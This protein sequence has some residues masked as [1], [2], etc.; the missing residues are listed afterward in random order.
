MPPAR[1]N[2]PRMR[3]EDRRT[4]TA[5][6]R[7]ALV[8][9][10]LGAIASSV[11]FVTRLPS[12]TISSVQVEHAVAH[13]EEAIRL[14]A[15]HVLSGSYAFVIPKRF[16]YLVSEGSLRAAILD[17]VPALQDITVEQR[18]TMLRIEVE[19][20]TP[21][22]LWCAEECY[23]ID[24][25]GYAFRAG[26][27]TSL[28][29]YRGGNPRIGETVHPAFQDLTRLVDAVASA[30]GTPV[31]VVRIADSDVVATLASG[32]EVR[33]VDTGDART[34]EAQVRAVLTSRA[35]AG[36]QIEYI[37][38]RFAGKVLAKFAR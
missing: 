12:V 26:T 2:T 7:T 23:L 6:F 36:K 27:D 20:R 17:A 31:E 30:A 14:A 37:E 21:V 5:Y 11:A 34:L 4:R 16:S 25:H 33:F 29:T 28:R 9:G 3:L 13:E 38:L 35:A 18:G 32:G 19:E 1:K 22:A 24:A 15:E 10:L 8:L